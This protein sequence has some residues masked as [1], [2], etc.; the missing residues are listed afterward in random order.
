MS[1][2]VWQ[3]WS[4]WFKYQAVATISIHPKCASS[5]S[6]LTSQ[7]HRVSFFP[8]PQYIS[9]FFRLMVNI[10]TFFWYF[11]F[12]HNIP[13]FMSAIVTAYW[14]LYLLP[15]LFH[16]FYCVYWDSKRLR[17]WEVRRE[18]KRK[19][20]HENSQGVN[21]LSLVRQIEEFIR[22]TNGIFYFHKAAKH[23]VLHLF[24]YF[25]FGLSWGKSAEL[26]P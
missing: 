11:Y 15:F 7:T 18:W 16:S 5:T 19:N 9:F 4:I 3:R 12:G 6:I 8:F 25:R 17:G 10:H 14:K 20:F 21:C 1:I 2:S 23:R 22:W 26:K 24:N 13:I